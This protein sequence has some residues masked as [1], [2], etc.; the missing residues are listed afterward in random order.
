VPGCCQLETSIPR[1]R[2]L[3][4][5][6]VTN[7]VTNDSANDA[8][9]NASAATTTRKNFGAISDEVEALSHGGAAGV[10]CNGAIR[11]IR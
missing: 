8:Q 1:R 9:T 6:A 3:A 2:A 11:K 5:A 7:D 4:G 10:L